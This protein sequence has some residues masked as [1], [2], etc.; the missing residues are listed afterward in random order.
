ML[1][2]TPVADGAKHHLQGQ[3]R[4]CK[5]GVGVVWGQPGHAIATMQLGSYPQSLQ[6][7]C[8]LFAP[9][10]TNLTLGQA[11]IMWTRSGLAMPLPSQ[12][13]ATASAA[14]G[15]GLEGM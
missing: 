6:T 15:V 11:A 1:Q 9:C 3:A 4:H 12:K 13:A 2:E 7:H 8:T 5:E 14:M 10:N